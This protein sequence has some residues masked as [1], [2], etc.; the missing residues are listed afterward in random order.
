MILIGHSAGAQLVA[1][2]STDPRYA[3]RWGVDPR[4][5]VGTVPLDGVYDITSQAGGPRRALFYNAFATPAENAVDD[6]W[7]LASPVRFAGPDDPEMLVVTQDDLPS[8]IAGSAALATALGPGRGAVLTVPYDHGEINAAVGGAD[9]PAGETAAIMSFIDG[10]LR[11]ARPP[12]VRM[13]AH[14][15]RLVKLRRHG[16]RARVSFRFRAKGVAKGFEC[17]L[18]GGKYRRCSSPRSYAVLRG[19]HG[20]RVRAIGSDGDRGEATRFE[21][22]VVAPR[23]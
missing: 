10:A 8:R 13:T 20:F 6:A 14:P 2:V 7:A 18:D 17:R 16:R 15:A 11:A 23:R 5:L 9:D 22:R 1:L 4:Q 21:F 12:R 19:R 3:G